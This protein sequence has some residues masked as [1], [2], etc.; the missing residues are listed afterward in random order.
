M[1]AR[2]VEDALLKRCAA[3]A[4]EAN[5][6]A[7]DQREANVFR[8]AAMVVQSRFPHEA[9][10][11]MVASERYF[12]TH[13]AEQLASVEVIRRG[14]VANLPRLRDRLSRELQLR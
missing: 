14:W 2:E 8:L 13:P 1:G 7:T 6:V 3:V 5:L 11:L 10:R 12:A 4:R 9:T